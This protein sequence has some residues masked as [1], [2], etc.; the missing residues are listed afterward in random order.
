MGTFFDPSAVVP[1]FF[2]RYSSAVGTWNNDPGSNV[3]QLT[4]AVI[5]FI[6]TLSVCSSQ[7]VFA[8]FTD[9]LSLPAAVTI[10]TIVL[11]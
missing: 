8:V 9:Q 5:G 6:V 7:Y 10:E 11:F 3:L 1:A 4:Q 2:K